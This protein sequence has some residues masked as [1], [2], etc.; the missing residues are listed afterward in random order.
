MPGNR[1]LFWFQNLSRQPPSKT[2]WGSFVMV[3]RDHYPGIAPPSK[4]RVPMGFLPL[5]FQGKQ[6]RGRLV[7]TYE[8]LPTSS[9]SLS[10]P[11]ARRGRRA[12]GIKSIGEGSKKRVRVLPG[13]E[14][15]GFSLSKSTIPP[16]GV[17][18]RVSI[19]RIT[20]VK[21]KGKATIGNP[22]LP[23]AGAGDGIPTDS[24]PS[25]RT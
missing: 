6:G 8:Q 11:D 14:P 17:R 4:G 1:L 19:P 13:V 20:P 21:T 15:C 25:R 24:L 5:K 7:L 9:L 3:G 2:D 12:Q 10:S 23:F 16:F 18:I 22:P